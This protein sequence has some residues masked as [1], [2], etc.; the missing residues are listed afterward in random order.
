MLLLTTEGAAIEALGGGGVVITGGGWGSVV[1]FGGE[2]AGRLVDSCCE[3][4][5]V[6]PQ[7]ATAKLEQLLPPLPPAT[8]PTP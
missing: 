7:L 2:E 6:D 4:D 5:P 8:L 1:R 3:P